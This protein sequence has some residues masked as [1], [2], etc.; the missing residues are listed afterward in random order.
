MSI[1]I[2]V[3]RSFT[4]LGADKLEKS[5]IKFYQKVA[6]QL[7]GVILDNWNKG[8]SPVQG[9]GRFQQ[10][11]KSYIEQIEH[12]RKAERSNNKN[13]EKSLKKGLVAVD[14]RAH[15][16]AEIFRGKQ[17]SP[18]NL[19]LTGF[20]HKSIRATADFLKAT[21]YIDSPYAKYHNGAGKVD[22]HILPKGNESFSSLIM[23][24]LR[25]LLK[26][27]FK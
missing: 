18:V 1:S 22:R 17:R 10:Y 12:N 3:Q 15:G 5:K 14:K 16:T 19:R 6:D 23:K 2:K 26:E 21:I 7:P 13:A 27:S 24:K 20:M 11:S 8:I 4:K 25:D 9:V